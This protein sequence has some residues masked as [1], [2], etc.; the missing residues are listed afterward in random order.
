MEFFAQIFPPFGA[1]QLHCCNPVIQSRAFVRGTRST[2][3]RAGS[4][5][6]RLSTNTHRKEGLL[7][8]VWSVG[9]NLTPT[10]TARPLKPILQTQT[11]PQAR[12]G[13][14]SFKG[15]FSDPL[16]GADPCVGRRSL[17]RSPPQPTFSR[18]H[19]QHAHSF[20]ESS[21]PA[22]QYTSRICPELF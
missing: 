8:S 7:Y 9:S 4:E 19:A 11:L 20:T 2:D 16:L 3:G 21:L 10:A 17:L 22:L 5:D 14:G 15:T 1:P 13:E 18:I 12:W 6:G